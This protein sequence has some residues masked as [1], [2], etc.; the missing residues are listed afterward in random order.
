MSGEGEPTADLDLVLDA[1][2]AIKWYIPE[3]L[4]AE[5]RRF[6][7]TLT[8]PSSAS[9]GANGSNGSAFFTSSAGSSVARS[10]RRR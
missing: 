1:S 5:S 4:S 10:I 8:H 3:D 9:A 2:V 6:R 7:R